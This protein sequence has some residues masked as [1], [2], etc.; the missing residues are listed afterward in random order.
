MCKDGW[1]SYLF[2]GVNLELCNWGFF[3]MVY[4]R[5][6]YIFLYVHSLH[7]NFIVVTFFRAHYI[8]PCGVADGTPIS[9]EVPVSSPLTFQFGDGHTLFQEYVECFVRRMH[10]SSPPPTIERSRVVTPP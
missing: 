3:I 10:A 7:C 6:G 2:L 8:G 1:D 4:L 5:V 9:K